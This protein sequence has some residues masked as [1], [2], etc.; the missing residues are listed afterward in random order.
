MVR[1]YG[2]GPYPAVLHLHGSG[3]TVA[4]S[5]VLLR[6]F[7]RA[8]YVAMDVEY[9]QIDGA[10]IDLED[11]YASLEFLKRSRF[12]RKGLV[13]LNGF[14][15]GARTALRVAANQEVRAVSAIA[16]RTSAGTASTSP[17]RG[18]S[19]KPT[20]SRCRFSCNTGRRIRSCRTRTRCSSSRS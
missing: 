9:R 18:V 10:G 20:G 5:V 4:K 13:G 17:S 8:G 12:V 14:S 7:A 6:V 19:T 11:V 16:A 15:L 3:E 1:P 2:S